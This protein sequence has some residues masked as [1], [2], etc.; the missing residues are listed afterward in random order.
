MLALSGI[1]VAYGDTT[2]VT[3]IVAGLA[4]AVV[5]IVAPSRCPRRQRALHHPA[6]IAIAVAAIGWA[7]DR[8]A[9]T[10]IHPQAQQRCTAIEEPSPLIADDA[11]HHEPASARRSL[12]VL[13]VGLLAW[14]VPVVTVAVFTG[15]GSGLTAQDCSSPA[16]PWSRS[17]ARTPCSPS[18]PNERA[19]STASFLRK[20]WSAAWRWPNP[21]PARSSWWC[22]SWR[23]W[24]AYANPG[25]LDPWIG[26]A[27][28][29]VD[30]LD[31]FI[32]IGREVL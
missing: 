6:L 8:F 26:G 11:L 7:L 13:G 9:P 4:P 28:S 10:I 5:A 31:P 3:A 21:P 18:S 14:V 17:A 25:N 15:V 16:Q 12:T 1:Y 32:S 27:R 29:V 23:S 20:T 19:R 30:R 2:L 22:S 24:G